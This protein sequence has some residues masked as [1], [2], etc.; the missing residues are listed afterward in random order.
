MTATSPPT[1]P[2]VPAT[3]SP[4]RSAVALDGVTR[5]YRSKAGEVHALRGVT[6]VFPRGSFT[7]VMGPSGSGK[8]ALLQVAAGLDRPTHG[9]VHLG[10][11]ALSTLSQTALTRVRRDSMAFV[12][13]SYNLL[14]ALTAYEN[15]ALPARLAG[16]RVDRA[17]VLDALAKVGLHG[18]AKRRPNRTPSGAVLPEHN[19]IGHPQ[20][21]L[22]RPHRDMGPVSSDI[23][24]PKW[25][26]SAREPVVAARSS[27]VRARGWASAKRERGTRWC[28]HAAAR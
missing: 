3:P 24:L 25:P 9:E 22:A 26:V 20:P 13:Q 28:H 7:A 8:S 15:V 14:D 19:P 10:E 5:T 17:G 6:H 21:A 16:R 11:V 12:F 18:L 2:T 1:T 27:R 4:T 23:R